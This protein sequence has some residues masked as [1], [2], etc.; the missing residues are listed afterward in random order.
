VYETLR[1]DYLAPVLGNDFLISVAH[2][3]KEVI[4]A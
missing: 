2:S 3:K 1:D 4:P